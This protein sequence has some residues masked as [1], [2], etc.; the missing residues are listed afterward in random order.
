[1]NKKK[2]NQ[3]G[4]TLIEVLLSIIIL[5]ITL[6]SFIGFFTQ[7]ALFSQKNEQK[8]GAM[9]IAQKV[10]S[11]IEI[12]ITKQILQNDTIIDSNGYVKNMTQ[13]LSKTQIENYIHETI[14]SNFDVTA[15]I[16]NNSS[17]NLILV[18]LS[19]KNLKN[20]ENISETYTYIRR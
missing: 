2:G 11:L 17:E 10:I 8:L 12:D 13:T 14:D 9:Q 16:T 18:K 15:R 20:P 3:K 7:S 1:M 19:V 5:F 6:T 4:F